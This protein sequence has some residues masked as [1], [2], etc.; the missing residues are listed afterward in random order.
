[1][2]STALRPLGAVTGSYWGN[3]HET[4]LAEDLIRNPYKTVLQK[5]SSVTCTSC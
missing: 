2:V 1:M 3:G 5:P 4:F